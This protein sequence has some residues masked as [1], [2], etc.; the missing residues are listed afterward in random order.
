[1]FETLFEELEGM[2]PGKSLITAEEVCRFLSCEITVVYNWNKR[3]NVK[4]RPPSI[5]VGKELRYSKKLLAK[6]LAEEQSRQTL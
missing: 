3:C 6:W 2:Y 4:R 5:S 1:M